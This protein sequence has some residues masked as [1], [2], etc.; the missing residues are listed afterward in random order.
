MDPIASESSP[1]KSRLVSADR[2][3]EML[4]WRRAESM[5][6]CCL[7]WMAATAFPLPEAEKSWL[8]EFTTLLGA[9]LKKDLE[10]EPWVFL[11]Y[12]TA[13]SRHDEFIR[14]AQHFMPLMGLGHRPG[15]ELADMPSEAEIMA[16]VEEKRKIDIT[17]YTSGYAYWFRSKSDLPQRQLFQG[18]GG[19]TM[20][21]RKPDPKAKPPEVTIPAQYRDH[22][23]FKTFDVQGLLEGACAMQDEFL[24]KS[25]LVFGADMKQSAQTEFLPF[26]L[27][28]LGTANF[29]QMEEEKVKAAFDLFDVY[30][31]ESPGDYGIVLAS[32]QDLDE[33]LIELLA[34]MRQA[35]SEAR[36]AQGARR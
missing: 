28:L 33:T 35:A 12:Q 2:S 11:D 36:T 15:S 32:Q 10:A 26:I 4:P 6:K 31:H 23:L 19:M 22:Q 3:K 25:K 24:K 29:F 5:T 9:R 30:L 18:L 8:M 27:P 14:Q 1:R 7:Y 17:K 21:Y 20:V 34:A 13:V 16:A